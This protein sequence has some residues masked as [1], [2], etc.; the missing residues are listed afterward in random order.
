MIE[1][2]LEEEG[3]VI[4]LSTHHQSVIHTFIHTSFI[5]H[6]STDKNTDKRWHLDHLNHDLHNQP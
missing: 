5:Y 1:I 6:V 2:N 4:H 3:K